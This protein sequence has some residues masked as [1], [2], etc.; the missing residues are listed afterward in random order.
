MGQGTYSNNLRS[1]VNGRSGGGPVAAPGGAGYRVSASPAVRWAGLHDATGSVS[2]RPRGGKSR[3]PLEPHKDRLLGR[4]GAGV[5]FD[6][7]GAGTAVLE[8]GWM[9]DERALD[10][11][12]LQAARD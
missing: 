7:A 8:G 1:R 10:P 2:P 5:G 4:R 3:S 9:G 12:L 6:L 11:P